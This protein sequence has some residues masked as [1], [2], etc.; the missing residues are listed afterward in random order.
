MSGKKPQQPAV[1]FDP[2]LGGDDGVN[3]IAEEEMSLDFGNQF[4]PE[5]DEEETAPPASEPPADDTPPPAP[6]ETEAEPP[7]ETPSE[8]PPAQ[9]PP[10]DATIP[11]SRLERETAKRREL[12]EMNRRL[13]EKIRQFE[14]SVQRDDDTRVSVEFSEDIQKQAQ[15]IFQAIGDENLDEASEMFNNVLKNVAEQAALAATSNIDEKIN[16]GAQAVNN[17]QSVAGAISELKQRY[18]ELDNDAEEFNEESVE[19]TLLFQRFFI[20]KGLDPASALRRAAEKVMGAAEGTA[21][22]STTPPERKPS[23]RDITQAQNSQPPRTRGQTNRATDQVRKK[24]ISEMSDE[25]FEQL[26][27]KELKMLRGD[28]F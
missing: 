25:E 12:E 24:S 10:E 19:E 11:K 13:Q 8:T 18:P 16:R 5:D 28:V 17:Q 14:N 26:S 7:A 15:K 3:D 9:E 2:F 20:D 27:G 6:D 21:P 22:V 1:D 23:V 4:E